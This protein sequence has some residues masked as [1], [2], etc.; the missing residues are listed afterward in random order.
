MEWEKFERNVGGSRP[1]KKVL[2]GKASL[3][4]QDVV[5][6]PCNPGQCKH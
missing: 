1:V 5:F 2:K 4:A 6:I 3:L